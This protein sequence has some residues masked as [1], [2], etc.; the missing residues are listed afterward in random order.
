MTRDLSRAFLVASGESALLEAGATST[1][2]SQILRRIPQDAIAR[3]I[4][5]WQNPAE[6]AKFVL[7]QHRLHEGLTSGADPVEP[8][9]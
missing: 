3:D 2:L 8:Q 5:M 6:W 4:L 7:V 9:N 1:E